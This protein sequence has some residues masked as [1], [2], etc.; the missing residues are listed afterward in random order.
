MCKRWCSVAGGGRGLQKN[1]AAMI[2]INNIGCL[3]WGRTSHCSLNS[4]HRLCS[5]FSIFSFNTESNLCRPTSTVA[6][7]KDDI[8]SSDNDNFRHSAKYG[9]E[10]NIDHFIFGIYWKKSRALSQSVKSNKISS[11]ALCL[12]NLKLIEKLI[13]PHGWSG[14]NSSHWES[15]QG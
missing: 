11:I 1:Q 3:K 6:G 14:W 7:Q 12:P 4:R 10:I 15:S 2:K 9:K 5:K 13:N 8:S